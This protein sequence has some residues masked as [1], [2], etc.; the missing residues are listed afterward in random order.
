[1]KSNKNLVVLQNTETDMY[2]NWI[3]EEECIHICISAV[4]EYFVHMCMYGGYN[5]MHVIWLDAIGHV[6][7]IQFMNISSQHD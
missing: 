7:S 1:M 2:V 5:S 3:M 6:S 4:A